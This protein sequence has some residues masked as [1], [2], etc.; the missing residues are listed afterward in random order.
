MRVL[1]C[2]PRAA[3]VEVE[4]L[5]HALGLYAELRGDPPEG[6]T[7]FVPAA[8]TVLVRYDPARTTMERLAADLARRGGDRVIQTGE[9]L[10]EVPV[11]Y[12][13]EDL[14]EVSRLAGM[15]PRE[16]VTQHLAGDYTVAFSGFSPGFA[17]ITGLHPTL[18]VP[19]RG[20][21]RTSLPAGAVAIAD[22]F[23]SIYPR[24]SPGGWRI[25]GHTETPVWDLDRDPPALLT[26][27]G[28][29]RFIEVTG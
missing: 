4:D 24:E 9:R 15:S 16:V 11:R 13:G 22:Q 29:V 28:R 1:R 26:P 10:V 20:T 7:E 18:H 27:G 19:R 12:D 3:L 14:A 2:G 5:S 21:P 8:R 23:T 17:Y 25:I 6:A